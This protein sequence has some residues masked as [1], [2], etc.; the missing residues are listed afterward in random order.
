MIAH[1]A[2][3]TECGVCQVAVVDMAAGV[4]DASVKAIRPGSHVTS[5]HHVRSGLVRRQHRL[6]SNVDLVGAGL[7][8]L[9]GLVPR[10]VGDGIS[11]LE[12]IDLIDRFN[13]RGF[14]HQRPSLGDVN[15]FGA[16]RLRACSVKADD[17]QLLA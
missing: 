17:R 1:I 7:E 10:G 14:E 2:D 3:T 8:Q 15:A 5:R 12:A 9:P 11:H 6:M 16:Q 4:I 13:F